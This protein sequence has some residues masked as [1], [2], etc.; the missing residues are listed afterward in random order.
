MKLKKMPVWAVMLLLGGST[1]GLLAIPAHANEPTARSVAA[2]ESDTSEKSDSAADA[3]DR[4]R[5]YLAN[6]PLE[7]C[8]KRWDE[9][10]HMSK[11]AW[12]KSC[13]RITEERAPYVKDR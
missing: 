1:S 5:V 7:S 3:Q 6:E 9:G 8:M 2:A 11:D 4:E 12:R 13:Q 10:T